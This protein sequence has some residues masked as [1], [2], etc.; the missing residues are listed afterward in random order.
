MADYKMDRAISMMEDVHHM[1]GVDHREFLCS[2]V[3]L[4]V[5]Q[6]HKCSAWLL[7][8]FRSS[9][10]LFPLLFNLFNWCVV[11]FTELLGKKAQT[12]HIPS[13]EY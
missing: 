8:S 13:S 10:S 7:G 5:I 6:N 11:T 1:V 4:G 2:D 9:K 12:V 3:L